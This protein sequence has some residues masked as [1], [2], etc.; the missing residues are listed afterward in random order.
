MANKMLQKRKTSRAKKWII[1]LLVLGIVTVLALGLM[2]GAVRS[3]RLVNRLHNRASNFFTPSIGYLHKTNLKTAFRFEGKKIDY[4]TNNL[5]FRDYPRQMPKPKDSYRILFL[6]DSFLEE[7]WLPMEQIFPAVLESR[8]KGKLLKNKKLEFLNFGVLGFGTG[9]EYYLLKEYGMKTEPDFVV[10]AFFMNDI[11]D[12]YYPP[13]QENG[14]PSFS[15]PGPVDDH[16]VHF[17]KLPSGPW[18]T[19]PANHYP[20]RGAFKTFTNENFHLYQFLGDDFPKLKALVH[21]LSD[22]KATSAVA[23]QSQPASGNFLSPNQMLNFLTAPTPEVEIG[24][25]TTE[26]SLKS[27][28]DLLSQKNIPLLVVFLPPDYLMNQAAWEKE[29]KAKGLHPQ[30]GNMALPREKLAALCQ[31]LGIDLVDPTPQFQTSSQPLYLNTDP[32]F[33]DTGHQLVANALEK[34]FNQKLFQTPAEAK[35]AS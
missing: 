32:H 13:L 6:G 29:M 28:Q 22:S 1:N 19:I 10:V 17:A 5:G 25:E 34:Y 11:L 27:I 33:N 2:E 16:L 14:Q 35:P 20:A 26:H 3:F 15:Y 18:Q 4:Q 23:M 8:F 30:V 24:W 21:K 12:N 31:K 7:P 9:V